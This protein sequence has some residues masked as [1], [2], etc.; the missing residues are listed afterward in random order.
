[1]SVYLLH[2]HRKLKHA[3]HYLGF[4]ASDANLDKRLTDHLCGMGARIMEVCFERSIEW[5]CVRV[6]FGADR[7][8]ERRLKRFK[9]AKVLCPICNG[10]RAMNR[11][12]EFPNS[13][14]K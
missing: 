8:F 7:S 1:M 14:M 2:F 9:G 13:R 6:W 5:R 12:N 10:G 4:V 3:Q 11:A